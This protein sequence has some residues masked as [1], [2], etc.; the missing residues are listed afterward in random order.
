MRGKYGGSKNED[1][2][3]M[4]SDTRWV[5]LKELVTNMNETQ[6]SELDVW[7]GKQQKAAKTARKKI[8]R[9]ID[10]AACLV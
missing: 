1:V 3:D 6:L 8:R 7:A 5:Q 9:D 4:I 2:D 10:D